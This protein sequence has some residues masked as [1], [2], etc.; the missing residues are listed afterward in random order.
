MD[1]LISIIIPVYNVAPYIHRCMESVLGQT[2]RNLEIILVNDG[3]TDRS[4]ELCDFYQSADLRVKVIHKKNGGQVSA[5]KKGLEVASGSHVGYVD[6]DD[7]IDLDM[8]EGLMKLAIQHQADFIACGYIKEEEDQVSV[9]V[10]NRIP[11]GIYSGKNLKDIIYPNMFK[12]QSESFLD[13]IV[14]S[15]CSKLY[16]KELLIQNQFKVD[17]QLQINEDVACVYPCVLNAKK[18]YVTDKCYYHYRIRSD[19]TMRGRRTDELH[20]I[21]LLRNQLESCFLKNEPTG[22]LHEQLEAFIQWLSVVSLKKQLGLKTSAMYLFPYRHIEK[23]SAII[24]WGAGSV[25]Q[26]YYYQASHYCK[27][28]LWIDSSPEPAVQNGLNVFPPEKIK[29]LVSFDKVVIAMNDEKIANTINE[30]LLSMGVEKNKIFWQ[31]PVIEKQ[32]F[33]FLN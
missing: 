17:D 31:K 12:F 23:N 26:S 19:S 5:K 7:W 3:S 29:E 21:F 15:G 8:Y 32:G 9:E 22:I 27:I 20:Q 33:F 4:G 10:K 14:S 28:S 24:L 16:E 13:G 1:K 18:V 6:P 11:K 25:G 2:Y 30:Q